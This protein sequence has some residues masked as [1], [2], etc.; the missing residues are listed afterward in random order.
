MKD[1]LKQYSIFDTITF[2]FPQLECLYKI[3]KC[4]FD[5][6][7]GLIEKNIDINWLQEQCN[8]SEFISTLWRANELRILDFNIENESVNIY[9]DSFIGLSFYNV[10]LSRMLKEKFNEI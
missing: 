9:L 1:L 5:T 8:S 10:S 7:T 4:F 6:E 3:C 2:T